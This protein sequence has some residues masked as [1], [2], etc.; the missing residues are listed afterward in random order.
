MTRTVRHLRMRVPSESHA[1]QLQARLDDALRCASLPDTG[2]RLLLVRRL[3]LGRM[4]AGWGAQRLSLHIERCV[5]AAGLHW[6]H[7]DAA[8]AA[9]ASAVWFASPF[10][11]M[12]CYAVRLASGAGAAAWHWRL[13]LPAEVLAPDADAGE[14]LR[15]IVRELVLSPGAVNTVPALLEALADAGHARWARAQTLPA[16]GALLRE[17]GVRLPLSWAGGHL[18]AAGPE[19]TPSRERVAGAVASEADTAAFATPMK[20]APQD[21]PHAQPTP[22]TPAR[23]RASA[24]RLSLAAQA[25]FE[26]APPAPDDT[27][28]QAAFVVTDPAIADPVAPRSGVTLTAADAATRGLHAPPSAA[29]DAPS[30]PPSRLHD[31]G[32]ASHPRILE[33]IGQFTAAGGLLC[34]VPVLSRMRIDAVDSELAPLAQRLLQRI[35]ARLDLHGDDATWSLAAALAAP[36]APRAADLHARTTHWLNTLRRHLRLQC[37]IGLASLAL[38]PGWLDWGPTHIDVHLP[39]AQVDLRIRRAGLDIDPGWVPW[40]QRIVRFHYFSGRQPETF[41]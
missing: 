6:V 27:S 10:E 8:E 29:I 35:A 26:T 38:R 9:E 31:D 13:A 18:M 34:L 21:A 40:L 28:M 4:P 36:D 7:G 15:R 14:R 22:A 32:E 19:S 11:A 17:H 16:L 37:G 20:A 5:Q 24:P 2:E 30:P 12:R 23:P 1:W 25:S 39:L 3:D 41:R 33:A